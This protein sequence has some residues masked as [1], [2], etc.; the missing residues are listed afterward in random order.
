MEKSSVEK[1]NDVL[2]KGGKYYVTHG[3][4]G[5][6]LSEEEITDMEVRDAQ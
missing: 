1:L 4:E 5:H 6:K 2:G 3:P